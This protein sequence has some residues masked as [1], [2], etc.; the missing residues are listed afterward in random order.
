M[1]ID[2]ARAATGTG[3]RTGTGPVH[4]IV[5]PA[6]RSGAA[7]FLRGEVTRDLARRGVEAQFVE[8]TGPGDAADIAARAA[9]A[10]APAVVA[11]GGDGTVHDVANG[12]LRARE[13]RGT[14]ETAL[15]I[16]PCGTGNDFARIVAG[17]VSRAQAYEALAARRVRMVDA[18][19][20]RWDGG[21]EYFING[22]GTGIDVDVVRHLRKDAWMPA[23]FIYL[24]ALFRALLGF[25]PVPLRLEADGQA[26][27]TRVMM[28]AICNG[29]RIGGAF[30]VCP[31]SRPDDGL[32]DACIV[33]ALPWHA[34]PAT[35]LAV[36]RGSHGRR[37]RV[38]MLRAAQFTLTVPGDAPLYVQLD[39]ELRET[40][41]ART[42]HVSVLPGVLPV[43]TSA[44]LGA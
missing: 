36:L 19:M 25:R 41:S 24:G 4:V 28:A 35:L 12:L 8:T 42:L 33:E 32:L 14:L 6:A 10:R 5:N 29:R 16:V 1:N 40:G 3:V 34:I 20:V 15:A 17:I 2:P 44:A 26:F 31:E 37:P 23:G 13:T 7:A 30:H 18:G 27:D 39:G 43:L 22:M 38:R 21:A 11:I 9:A